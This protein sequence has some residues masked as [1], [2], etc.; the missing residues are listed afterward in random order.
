MTFTDDELKRVKDNLS[1][2]GV[3]PGIDICNYFDEVYEIAGLVAR[4]EAAENC[5]DSLM[6]ETDCILS[7]QEAG[8][9]TPDGG[10]RVKYAGKWYQTQ[11]ID[12]TPKCNCG[13]DEK[14]EAWRKAAGKV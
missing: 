13:L 7:L 1:K 10:Y 3:Y 14:C 11:P 9:P 12:E 4:L 8:E 2:F 5:F 6:H